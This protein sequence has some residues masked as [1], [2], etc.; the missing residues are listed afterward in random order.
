MSTLKGLCCLPS[1]PI[2]KLCLIIIAFIT[3]SQQQV[4]LVT[5]GLTSQELAGLNEDKFNSENSLFNKDSPQ[6]NNRIDVIEDIVVSPKSV[7]CGSI[8]ANLTSITIRNPNHPEPNYTKGICETVIERANSS[9]SHLSVKLDQFELFGESFDGTCVH[10][11]FAIYTDL[12]IPVSP[13][14]C[15]NH[16][17]R[18]FKI[19]FH[20]NETSLILSIITS[21]LDHDRF[22]SIQVDQE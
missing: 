15:G 11:R 19:Q 9:I 6:D 1:T 8:V 13:V 22:W 12:N 4:E 21:E 2:K 5:N 17:G 18:K 3:I 16:N 14:L 7:D 10:D 20:N